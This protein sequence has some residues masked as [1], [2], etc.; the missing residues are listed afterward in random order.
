MDPISGLSIGRI[1]LGS[2]ALVS[3]PLAARMLMLDAA[4]NPQLPLMTRM[5]GSREVALGALTLA[6]SGEA[7]ERLV[8]TGAAVDTADVLAGLAAAAKGSVPKLTAFA[9][10][11]VAAGAAAT[12]VRALIEG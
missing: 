8:Q 9:F 5:F 10:T 1:V 3:P 6:S 11:A 12:G 7:R 2:V 4:A